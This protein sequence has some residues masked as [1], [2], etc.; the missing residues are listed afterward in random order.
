MKKLMLI[1]VLIAVFG[2]AT[3]TQATKAIAATPNGG[4]TSPITYF[5]LSGQVTY[6]YLTYVFVAKNVTVTATNYQTN[7]KTAT[8]TDA[9]GNYS[10]SVTQ[11]QYT[12][13]PHDSRGTVFTPASRFV[14]VINNSISG[15]NF[16]GAYKR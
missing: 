2:L 1:L 7:A 3:F 4:V 5:M 13:K 8:V 16:Q 9:N 10:I 15:L 11:G 6:K 14:S 12:V